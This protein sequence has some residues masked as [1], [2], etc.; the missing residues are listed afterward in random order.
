MYLISGYRIFS[1]RIALRAGS[2]LRDFVKL[3][4]EPKPRAQ[5]YSQHFK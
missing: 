1:K 4:R 3:L 5:K 2:Q